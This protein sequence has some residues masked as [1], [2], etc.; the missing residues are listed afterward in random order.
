MNRYRHLTLLLFNWYRFSAR[1]LR[2]KLMKSHGNLSDASSASQCGKIHVP[3]YQSTQTKYNDVFVQGEQSTNDAQD[4][5]Y[6]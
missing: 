6:E 3:D 2:V 4:R 5:S 1:K